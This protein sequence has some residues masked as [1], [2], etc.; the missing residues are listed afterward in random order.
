MASIAARYAEAFVDLSDE[1]GVLD[2]SLAELDAFAALFRENEELRDFLLDPGTDAAG[3]KDAVGEILGGSV[4][5]H[6][7]HFLYLLLDK[8]RIAFLPDISRVA[9]ELA[10]ARK[11]VMRIIVT[12]ATEPGPEQ[13]DR[14]RA[15]FCSLFG[16]TAVEAEVRIDPSLIGGVKVAVGDTI[17][18]GSVR[19]RLV[20]LQET[21]TGR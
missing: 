12:A 7:L 21:L 6:V 2:E 11:K 3:K 18:D 17:F 10:D 4:R 5:T 14:L 1:A 16:C 15:H 20:G 13:I 8:E 19:A 9:S